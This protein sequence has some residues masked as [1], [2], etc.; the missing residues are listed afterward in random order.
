MPSEESMREAQVLMC[1]CGF[2]ECPDDDGHYQGCASLDG[3]AFERV[4]TLLDEHKELRK[5][6]DQALKFVKHGEAERDTLRSQLTTAHLT[7]VDIR[8]QLAEAHEAM[9]KSVYYGHHDTCDEL[10][11]EAYGCSCGY[12]EMRAALR[13]REEK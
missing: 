12:V 5:E 10:L 6:R 8:R 4:A 11:S 2:D 3:V 9:R 7:L 1:S 13:A